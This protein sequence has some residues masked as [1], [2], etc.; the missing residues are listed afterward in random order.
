VAYIDQAALAA[1]ATFRSRVRMAVVTAAIQIAAEAKASQDTTV[2]DKRQQLVAEV[3]PN[4]GTDLLEAFSWAVAQ[5]AAI[6]ASSLDS[7]VQ[8]QVNS[9][10]NALAGIWAATD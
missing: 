3:L 10:W 6:T 7:D 4:G 2:Y 5:N 8:F 9:V 1:D